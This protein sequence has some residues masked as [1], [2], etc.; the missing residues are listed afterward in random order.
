MKAFGNALALILLLL[1]PGSG[2]AQQPSR[3]FPNRALFPVLLA[4]ARDPVT[5]ATVLGVSRNP[6]EHGSGV[7]LEV[8]LGATL[9]I[10]RIAGTED[11]NPVLIG[12]E[13]AA[14]ARFGLQVL[15]RDLVATD[16]V[17]AVPVI[18]HHDNGWTR[19]RYYHT[20][21]HMGDEYNRRFEDP[22]INSSRDAAEIFF[23]RKPTEVLGS[24]V[25]V[26]Y[27][28]NL[29][30]QEDERWVLRAGSQLE[31]EPDE[32]RFRPF[33]AADIEWDQ[34][35]GM[36]PRVEA[37]VGAWLP[38]M[39]GHR[40]LRISLVVLSGPSPLGQFRFRETTQVGLSLQGRL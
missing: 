20:S 35:A 21:S 22:G 28:Y 25:G 30:P 38:K 4:G 2:I 33:M 16:W 10:Y 31:V 29:H 5:S 26:R 23:F 40:N 6:S 34:E 19:F 32:G 13:A 15:E 11:R 18:W 24:W 14:F 17:L 9:P 36:R 7:E 12:I 1:F 39:D 3:V 27:G 37:R 8:S